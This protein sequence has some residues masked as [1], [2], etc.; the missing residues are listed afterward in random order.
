MG[1]HIWSI[2]VV[3]CCGSMTGWK[4]G[5]PPNQ[6][7][8]PRLRNLHFNFSAYKSH[9]GDSKLRNRI[10]ARYAAGP[11]SS[12]QI[13]NVSFI[14]SVLNVSLVEGLSFNV[15]GLELGQRS[16]HY[17][18]NLKKVV[19]LSKLESA[20]N[21]TKTMRVTFIVSDKVGPCLSH[22]WFSR[23]FNAYNLLQQQTHGILGAW[24][25]IWHNLFSLNSLANGFWISSIPP[26]EDTTKGIIDAHSGLMLGYHRA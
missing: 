9:R 17:N 15:D 23:Y 19:D 24:S 6:E 20:T 11:C 18:K 1:P 4:L 14:K 16:L 13:I 2:L 26:A 3:G 12:P 8:Q 5:D 25:A 22:V 7:T 10:R 21:F